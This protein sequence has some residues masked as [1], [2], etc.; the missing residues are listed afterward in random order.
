[1]AEN[2]RLKSLVPV[3]NCFN[4][5]MSTIRG[6]VLC[7]I[8]SAKV[9]LTFSRKYIYIFSNSTVTHNLCTT[10]LKSI[11]YFKVLAHYFKYRMHRDLYFGMS[12]VHH[13]LLQ[14]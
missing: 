9:M 10:L 13:C 6:E 7:E 2:G 12:Y 5:V 4:G 8:V 3:I 1:M 14:K 11:Y